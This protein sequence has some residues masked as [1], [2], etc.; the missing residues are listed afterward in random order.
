MKNGQ[1]R[2]LASLEENKDIGLFGEFATLKS[3]GFDVA[4]TSPYGIVGPKNMKPEVIE[5][6]DAA[7]KKAIESQCFQEAA[8]EFGLAAQYRDHPH[9]T[10][11]A[12]QTWAAEKPLMQSV[13]QSIAQAE[14]KK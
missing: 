8:V 14:A 6:L 5:K 4:A 9:Y 2:L 12:K 13:E 3:Q 7:F 1:I 10:D 11:Y